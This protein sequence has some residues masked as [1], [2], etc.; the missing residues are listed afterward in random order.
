MSKNLGNLTNCEEVH[1]VINTVFVFSYYRY[2]F[3][4]YGKSINLQILNLGTR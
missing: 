2:T 1:F 4:L 3:R